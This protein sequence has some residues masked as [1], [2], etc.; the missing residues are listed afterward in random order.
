MVASCAS[1]SYRDK[2]A[3]GSFDKTCR[4]SRS[5]SLSTLQ[6]SALMLSPHPQLWSTETGKCFHI[7]RGHTAEIV[8]L[9]FN[10]ASTVVA[11]GSMDTTARLWGVEDGKEMA[12]LAVGG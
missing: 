5:Q 2:I 4:V 3:T 8:C 11:T 10:P 12:T 7:F 1:S 6:A 9:T